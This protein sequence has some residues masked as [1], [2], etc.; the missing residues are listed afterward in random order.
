LERLSERKAVLLVGQKDTATLYQF[1]NAGSEPKSYSLHL[2]LDEIQA[3]E[4]GMDRLV[5]SRIVV[6]KQHIHLV[7]AFGSANAD[8]VIVVH[9]DFGGRKAPEASLQL[10]EGAFNEIEDIALDPVTGFCWLLSLTDAHWLRVQTQKPLSPSSKKASGS[11]DVSLADV[12][13]WFPLSSAFLPAVFEQLRRQRALSG[14]KLFID[15]L[16]ACLGIDA[17]ALFPP[18]SHSDLLHLIKAVFDYIE[19]N[20]EQTEEVQRRFH[21]ITRKHSIMYYLAKCDGDETKRHLAYAS[22]F[23]LPLRFQLLM[24]GY[25]AMDRAKYAEA[26][27]CFSDVTVEADWPDAILETLYQQQRFTEAA[28]FLDVVQPNLQDTESVK[29]RLDLM[30]SQDLTQALFFQVRNLSILITFNF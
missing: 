6:Q 26:V 27:L 17:S 1:E 19:P 3:A 9:K 2:V 30:I 18:A 10:V 28:F 8:K 16:L 23:G 12:K 29:I 7:A 15:R 25:W 13:P 11:F 4:H 20:D 24:D 22:H 14:G 5:A 21:E